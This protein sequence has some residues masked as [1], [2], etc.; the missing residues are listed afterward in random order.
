MATKTSKA[1]VTA[2]IAAGLA[3][4][5]AAAGYYFYG[6]DD[7]KKHRQMAAKWARDLKKEVTLQTKKLKNIDPEDYAKIVSAVAKRLSDARK[8]SLASGIKAVKK[9]KRMVKKTA[10]K[11]TEKSS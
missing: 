10:T 7:A 9:A 6:S 11:K 8:D 2:E 4:V 5:G 1:L 3:A